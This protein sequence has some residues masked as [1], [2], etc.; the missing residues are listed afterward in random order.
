M[1]YETLTEG[2]KVPGV[3]KIQMEHLIKNI[4]ESEVNQEIPISHLDYLFHNLDSDQSG[5]I[6]LK[7]FYELCET[8]QNSY[9]VTRTDSWL[10]RR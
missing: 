1:A 5:F 3:T 7:E 2:N 10:M 9:T 8:L 4:N 6:D